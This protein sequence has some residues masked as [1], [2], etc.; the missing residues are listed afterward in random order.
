MDNVTRVHPQPVWHTVPDDTETLEEII[1][2]YGP[3][4]YLWKAEATTG[5][6]Y[7]SASALITGTA[8]VAEWHDL[9]IGSVQENDGAGGAGVTAPTFDPNALGG[10]GA[11]IFDGSAFNAKTGTPN[12]TPGTGARSLIIV[13]RR[14]G[15]ADRQD[16]EDAKHDLFDFGALSA[17]AAG[18]AWAVNGEGTI[19]VVTGS[20]TFHVPPQPDYFRVHIWTAP[21]TDDLSGAKYYIDGT[22]V[23]ARTTVTQAVDTTAGRADIAGSPTTSPEDQLVGAIALI[24]AISAELSATAV[25]NLTGEL[26]T[27][28]G[29]PEVTASIP[30]GYH[31]RFKA[32]T[33]IYSDATA[34]VSATANS[35][36]VMRWD[37]DGTGSATVQL[38][39]SGTANS[40][41]LIL[42]SES[43]PMV[44]KN[45]TG[46][47]YGAA[48]SM[49]VHHT[50]AM[51]QRGY[52][53]NTGTNGNIFMSL[54]AGTTNSLRI[55]TMGGSGTN[56]DTHNNGG[57]RDFLTAFA[58]TK[59]AAYS[60]S[61][62]SWIRF[63]GPDD[64]SN[65]DRNHG[66]RL[67][68]QWFSTDEDS[69]SLLIAD[70]GPFTKRLALGADYSGQSAM[71]FL[72]YEIIIW[73]RRLTPTEMRQVERYAQ[74]QYADANPTA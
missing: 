72:I 8:V 14:G 51:I 1:E 40:F 54:A 31:L 49:Q 64:D 20:K 74:A 5:L 36:V 41:E 44:H 46:N 52:D 9:I 34:T 45:T 19:K 59:N 48:S 55:W 10:K 26:N 50:V 63:Y 53:G 43:R 28:Y 4:Q 38:I 56:N 27:Y 68:G 65:N 2:R 7:D 6:M 23:P 37:D 58:G 21:A 70:D 35:A 18:E 3:R 57:S 15:N 42:D 32:D 73:N 33:N 22:E 47:L 39:G 24:A 17:A 30:T 66:V 60:T 69:N 61:V 67:Y 13:N 71:K 12:W 11:V 62:W 25:T 29:L 16:V